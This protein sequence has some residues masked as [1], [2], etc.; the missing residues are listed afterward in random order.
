VLVISVRPSVCPWFHVFVDEKMRSFSLTAVSTDLFFSYPTCT[1]VRHRHTCSLSQI[2]CT[3]LLHDISRRFFTLR[4]SRQSASF[5]KLGSLNI[6]A[7]WEFVATAW[8]TRPQKCLRWPWS[9]PTE[10]NH[11]TVQK[12]IKNTNLKKNY[13]WKYSK[14]ESMKFWRKKINFQLISLTFS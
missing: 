4:R 7:S 11:G 2:H 10:Y 8:R 14:L 5:V 13:S 3:S 9:V 1:L 6:L 12:I